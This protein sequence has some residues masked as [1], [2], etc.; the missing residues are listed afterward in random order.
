MEWKGLVDFL[1][2][3]TVTGC[4]TAPTVVSSV[5]SVNDSGQTILTITFSEAVKGADDKPPTGFTLTNHTQGKTHSLTY[6]SGSGTDKLVFLV[7]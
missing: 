4:G 7:T 2:L 3:M 5:V 6:L 1:D